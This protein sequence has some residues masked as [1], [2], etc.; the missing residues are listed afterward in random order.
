MDAIADTKK[1]CV[2][3]LLRVMNQY[4]TSKANINTIVCAF[5]KEIKID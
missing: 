4:E 5:K 3:A 1:E 2:D